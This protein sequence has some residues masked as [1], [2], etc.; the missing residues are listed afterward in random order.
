M[1]SP[2]TRQKKKKKKKK[3]RQKTSLKKKKKIISKVAFDPQEHD[4]VST[5]LRNWNLRHPGNLAYADLLAEYASKLPSTTD[6]NYSSILSEITQALIKLITEEKGGRF[7]KIQGGENHPNDCIV[8]NYKEAHHK[9]LQALKNKQR[10]GI[11]TTKA[12]PIGIDSITLKETANK[13]EEDDD[14]EEE[15]LKPLTKEEDMQKY[16]TKQ[17]DWNEDDIEDPNYDK[18]I[19]DFNAAKK[20]TNT[21]SYTSTTARKI[22]FEEPEEVKNKEPESKATKIKGTIQEKIDL[23]PYL[24]KAKAMIRQKLKAEKTDTVTIKKSRTKPIEIGGLK[25]NK[26]MSLEEP[27]YKTEEEK[28]SKKSTNTNTK[29]TAK[30]KNTTTI[31]IKKKYRKAFIPPT[32]R[33]TR[34]QLAQ[35]D[36]N[37]PPPGETK[38]QEDSDAVIEEAVDYDRMPELDNGPKET[39]NQNDMELE[40]NEESEDEKTEEMQT[41]EE[42]EEDTDEER[43]DRSSTMGDEEEESLNEEEEEKQVNWNETGDV[44]DSEAD[45]WKKKL[46]KREVKKKKKEQ[47]TRL[48]GTSP[49]PQST[50]GKAYQA[51]GK[52]LTTW[53]KKT[54]QGSEPTY[55]SDNS[56]NTQTTAPTSNSTRAINPYQKDS[57]QTKQSYPGFGRGGGIDVS[58]Y[59]GLGMPPYRVIQDANGQ[60]RG[61]GRSIDPSNRGI[62]TAGRG[63]IQQATANPIIPFKQIP[64]ILPETEITAISEQDPNITGFHFCTTNQNR[65]IVD[66]LRA[67]TRSLS[68]H[69]MVLNYKKEESSATSAFIVTSCLDNPNTDQKW[70]QSFFNATTETNTDSKATDPYRTYAALY[71]KNSLSYKAMKDTFVS[72][73]GT[74]GIA[75]LQ[76]RRWYMSEFNGKEALRSNIGFLMGKNPNHGFSKDFELRISNHLS[77]KCSIETQVNVARCN[78]RTTDGQKVQVYGITVDR[79]LARIITAAIRTPKHVNGLHI[80]LRAD[81]NQEAAYNTAILNIKYIPEMYTGIPIIGISSAGADHLRQELQANPPKTPTPIDLEST[82]LSERLGKYMVTTPLSCIAVVKAH[83]EILL[84][85]NPSLYLDEKFPQDPCFKNVDE[86]QFKVLTT[87]TTIPIHWLTHTETCQLHQSAH[88]KQAPQCPT[89]LSNNKPSQLWVHLNSTD[90]MHGMW[91][92][93]KNC[94]PQQLSQSPQLKTQSQHKDNLFPP[95]AA[96]LACPRSQRS[97]KRTV[98][99]NVHW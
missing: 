47:N 98:H 55:D 46:S 68:T 80:F 51:A 30:S 74:K 34:G 64:S 97:Q 95:A 31:K 62:R 71:I 17:T 3:K 79:S 45:N 12:Q 40:E 23:G 4:V 13:E 25:W 86:L 63:A 27:I 48:K 14:D 7:L 10:K 2:N 6:P 26:F 85:K 89:E 52:L 92:C 72:K 75:E 78:Y 73:L 49:E 58:Q 96:S 38:D 94:S 32:E 44:S 16:L 5:K 60:G 93:Q 29:K 54:T 35:E 18:M 19:I 76:A 57:N 11:P 21:S 88:Q 67:F 28:P 37:P 70:L 1:T 20:P 83:V 43:D 99:W 22:N 61:R 90:R 50:F 66:T 77:D 69:D 15:D 36:N 53:N 41:E 65:D 59:N 56:T 81:K 8:M 39:K 82:H 24:T 91:L 33:K 9:V 84:S 42:M 87:K